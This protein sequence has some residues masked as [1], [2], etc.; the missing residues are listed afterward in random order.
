MAENRKKQRGACMN[1]EEIRKH[2]EENMYGV[3][4]EGEKV[5]YE[6]LGPDKTPENEEKPPFFFEVRGGE[7]VRVNIEAN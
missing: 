5:T 7:L 2:Y 4:R 6:L 3:W 1:R